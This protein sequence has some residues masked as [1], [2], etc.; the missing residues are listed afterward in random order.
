M[1]PGNV[2]CE[3]CRIELKE[4]NEEAAQIYNMVRGQV[5][6]RF[7]GEIDVVVD[8]NHLAV[9]AAIDGYGIKKRTEVFERVMRTFYH[10][11]KEKHDK[12]TG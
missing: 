9:W 7:N 2:A 12:D 10:L 6:T 4:D 5:I 1:I 8:L 3:S 11:L